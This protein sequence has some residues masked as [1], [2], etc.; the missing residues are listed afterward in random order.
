M[1]WSHV[2]RWLRRFAQIATMSAIPVS[3]RPINKRHEHSMT[4]ISGREERDV[5]RLDL[6]VGRVARSENHR[7]RALRD[8]NH[9]CLRA[10]I[11]QLCGCHSSRVAK[12]DNLACID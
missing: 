5:A 12:F 6:V 3:T 11:L 9:I 2:V 8:L 7:D 1:I 4:L 10:G